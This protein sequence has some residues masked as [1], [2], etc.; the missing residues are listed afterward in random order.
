MNE[1]RKVYDPPLSRKE[2]VKGITKLLMQ[3]TADLWDSGRV[4]EW[5]IDPAHD[6]HAFFRSGSNPNSVIHLQAYPGFSDANNVTVVIR[7][8]DRQRLQ[9]IRAKARVNGGPS[10]GNEHDAVTR[11]ILGQTTIPNSPEY[12]MEQLSKDLPLPQSS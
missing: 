2:R 10:I 6:V 11:T 9:E 1:E 4:A 12:L 8:M 7:E 3:V 5:E